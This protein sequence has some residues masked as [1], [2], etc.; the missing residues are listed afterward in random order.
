M[1]SFSEETC[2]KV[3]GPEVFMLKVLYENLKYKIANIHSLIISKLEYIAIYY[4]CKNV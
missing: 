1:F 4:H 3:L 2:V